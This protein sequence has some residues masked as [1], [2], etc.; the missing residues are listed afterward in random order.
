[1]CYPHGEPLWRFWGVT[2][3]LPGIDA[4]DPRAK[5]IMRRQHLREVAWMISFS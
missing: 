3:I 1:M 4:S 5:E 2:A